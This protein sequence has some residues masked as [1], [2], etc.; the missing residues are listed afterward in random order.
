MDEKT[1]EILENIV[2]EIYPYCEEKPHNIKIFCGNQLSFEERKYVENC[3]R[4]K[5]GFGNANIV[6]VPEEDPIHRG[7]YSPHKN[8]WYTI[9][10]CYFWKR[11]QE[12]RSRAS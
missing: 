9:D 10:F 11:N 8:G 3:F 7:D 4:K 2:N 6:A 12:K 1:K 5:P